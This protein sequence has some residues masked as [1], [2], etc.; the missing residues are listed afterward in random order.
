MP[1]PLTL[2]DQTLPPTIATD[3]LVV[4]DFWA[5]WCG[6]CRALGPVIDRLAV[7]YDGRVAFGK[8]NVDDHPESAQ[9]HGVKSIPALLFFRDGVLVDRTVGVVPEVL[10]VGKLDALLRP[11]RTPSSIADVPAPAALASAA[12]HAA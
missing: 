4:V 8:V 7:Q 5:A 6:P 1:S 10:L 3:G 11:P 9:A 12:T 2:S